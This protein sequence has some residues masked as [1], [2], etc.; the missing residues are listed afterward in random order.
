MIFQ[1]VHGILIDALGADDDEI[2]LSARIEA[3][4]MAESIDFLDI[5]FRSSKTFDINPFRLLSDDFP[6]VLRIAWLALLP[7]EERGKH[8]EELFM[9]RQEI[10]SLKTKFPFLNTQ[11]AKGTKIQD[12]VTV[13]F[14]CKFIA[15]ELGVPW[16]TPQDPA[17]A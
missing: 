1:S 9:T 14:Y 7:E 5:N 17:A 3:D 10:E 12:I 11:Y 13:E 4:L 2:I 8:E 6:K 15:T 16:T